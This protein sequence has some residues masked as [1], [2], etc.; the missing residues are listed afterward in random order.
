MTSVDLTGEERAA[1]R[2]ITGPWWILLITG[3]LW[4]GISWVVLRFQES[5]ITTVGVIIG[6][7]FL[8]AAANEMILAMLVDAWK[9][10]HW[11]LA[12]LFALG[13]VWGFVQPK[14]A[15]WALASVVGLLFFLK[16]TFDIIEAAATKDVNDLWWL[17]MIAGILLV[18]LGFWASQQYY[19]ARAALILIWVGFGALFRGITEIVAAFH[20]KK[21]H[22]AV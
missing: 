1:V 16:G 8:V 11:L 22:D 9:W 19:P 7:V 2:T 5:S 15:F 14:E 17:G 4:I 13:G 10:V 6:V 21:I 18:L 12:V 3:L 20:L